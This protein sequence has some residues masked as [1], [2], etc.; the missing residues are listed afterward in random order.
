MALRTFAGRT[1]TAVAFAALTL[2]GSGAVIPPA[3]ITP[4]ATLALP[5]RTYSLT[6]PTRAYSV[7]FTMRSPQLTLPARSYAIT[8][9]PRGQGGR[10]ALSLSKQPSETFLYTVFAAQYLPSGRTIASVEAFASRKDSSVTDALTEATLADASTIL[11]SNNPG[12]GARITI[13]PLGAKA[14]LVKASAVSGSNPC[15]VTVVPA[16]M[17]DHS[18]GDTVTYEP[19]FSVSVLVSTAPTVAG[20]GTE[21]YP[22]VT[23][24]IHLHT[25]RMSYLLTLDNGNVLEAES[26]LVCSDV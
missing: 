16:L 5:A 25:Y 15:T 22:N 4:V 19:G 10:V 26:D 18:Q 23:R 9:L 17:F 7:T 20:N 1:F 21:F 8:I 13:D 14:E 6:V 11:L 24:G 2:H 3:T 12:K